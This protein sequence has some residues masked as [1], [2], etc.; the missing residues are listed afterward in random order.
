[1]AENSAHRTMQRLTTFIE[2][3]VFLLMRVCCDAAQAKVNSHPVINRYL[4]PVSACVL[5][6]LL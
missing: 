2:A 3:L 5:T 4:Q 6:H 1:M